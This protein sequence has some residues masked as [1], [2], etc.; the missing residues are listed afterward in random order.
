MTHSSD[1]P[2]G[3]DRHPSK[4]LRPFGVLVVDDEEAVRRILGLGMLAH[5]FTVWLAANGLAAVELYR[6]HHDAIDV[7]LL[8]VRMPVRD[9]PET[10]AVLRELDPHVRF[11]FM[12]GD[13]GKYTEEN[14]IALGAMALF[15]KPLRLHELAQKLRGIALKPIDHPEAF[16]LNRWEDDGGR[17]KAQSQR[18]LE[19]EKRLQPQT[20]LQEA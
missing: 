16:Q 4:N 15:S 17:G 1:S 20:E 3:H 13:T 18:T 6:T 2:I 11:C 8:D 9:G 14:L 7:V 19:P 10:L 12:S 5:G